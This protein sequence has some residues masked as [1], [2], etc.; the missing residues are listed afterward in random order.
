[1]ILSDIIYLQ[2]KELLERIANDKYIQQLDKDKFIN[3]Y[4]KKNFSFVK[5]ITKNIT[6]KYSL[7]IK[8]ALQSKKN[9][10]AL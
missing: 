6:P 9:K 7:K 5:Q 8:R 2:N 4:H 3:S 1:M 10:V